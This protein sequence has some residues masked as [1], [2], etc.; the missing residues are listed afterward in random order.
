MLANMYILYI[1]PAAKPVEQFPA[2]P[3]ERRTSLTNRTQGICYIRVYELSPGNQ[4]S[5]SNMHVQR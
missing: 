4:V 5:G 1:I 2:V 3:N